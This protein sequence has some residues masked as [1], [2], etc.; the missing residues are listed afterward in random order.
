MLKSR[1][2]WSAIM[3]SFVLSIYSAHAQSAP[4]SGLYQIVSGTYT[5]CCGI[6]GDFGYSLPSAEQS[7]VRLAVDAQSGLASMTFL[8]E[9]MQTFGV[10]PCPPSSPISFNLDYG[11]MLADSIVFH[12]DPG[13]PPYGV[14]WSYWVTNSVNRLQIDGV[15]GMALQ[16]CTDVPN[17][18]NHSNVVAVLVPP[19][20]ISLT[21]IS[22]EGALL[23]IQG[24]AT[25]T[26]VVESSS[27]LVTWTPISTNVMPATLC[28]VCPYILFRDTASTNLARR[29]YRCFEF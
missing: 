15:L 7:F 5:E 25:R 4:T 3:G 22:N 29:F 2:I 21:E 14:F 9:D 24:Q 17:H 13:P 28:P 1:V 11:F 16:N 10:V 8:G 18:F 27:D 20:K 19:P 12:V 23:Y 26:N 6:A